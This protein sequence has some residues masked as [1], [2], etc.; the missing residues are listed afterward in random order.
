MTAI[1]DLLLEP[2]SLPFMRRAFLIGITCGVLCGVIGSFIVLRGMAFIGEAVAHSVFPGVAVSYAL[3][4]DLI[5]GGAVA[6]VATTIVIAAFSQNRRLKE[7]TVIGVFFTCAFGLGIVIVSTQSGY[8]GD[9]ASFL[10]G[11]ILAVSDTDVVTVAIASAVVVAVALALRKELVAVSLDRE[12]AAAAGLPVF[13]LDLALYVMVTAA[14][15]FSLQAIGNILVLGMLITPAAAARLFTDRLGTMIAAASGIGA[16]GALVG[17][18]F[19]YLLDLAAGGLI[20][21]VLT[22]FF[23]AAY[24]LAPR[25]GL[26]LKR[27]RAARA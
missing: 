3:G 7:D 11:Q 25:H 2:W 9:L 1:W 5:L 13:R 18:Y 26:V 14:I 22:L 20:V 10:F 17:L 23:V 15:V 12:T 19:S 8:T 24:L 4:A 21:V 6:G 16:T 27:L